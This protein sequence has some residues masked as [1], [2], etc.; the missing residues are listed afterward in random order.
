MHLKLKY[1]LDNITNMSTDVTFNAF[2]S[3]LFNFRYR[4]GK[5]DLKIEA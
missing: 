1:L 5:I 2:I 3:V 4:F